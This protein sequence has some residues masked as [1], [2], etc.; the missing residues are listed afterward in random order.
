MGVVTVRVTGRQ[1]SSS[2]HQPGSDPRNLPRLA[3]RPLQPGLPR[4]GQPPRLETAQRI[5][6]ARSLAID[7][8][9]LLAPAVEQELADPPPAPATVALV[10]E[11]IERIRH[12]GRAQASQDREDVGS[13]PQEPGESPVVA[14][15]LASLGLCP[16]RETQAPSRCVDGLGADAE[17]LGGLTVGPRR[18]REQTGPVEVLAGSRYGLPAR[19]ASS[20]SVRRET[21]S[22]LTRRTSLVR[23]TRWVPTPPG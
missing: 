13:R 15:G 12:R 4:R 1:G 22:P 5:L 8:G 10:G 19:A 18:G 2:P 21:W 7:L 6:R 14:P 23:G 16:A 9:E 17:D 11:D 3:P 20:S